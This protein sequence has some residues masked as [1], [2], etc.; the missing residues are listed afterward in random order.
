MTTIWKRGACIAA[1]AF[2]AAIAI[3]GGANAEEK[4]FTVAVIMPS[5]DISY[6]QWSPMARRRKR[7]SSA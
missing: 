7:K 3:G 2:C 1:A 4:K 5:L 6:W